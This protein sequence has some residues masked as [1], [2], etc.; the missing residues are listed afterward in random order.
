[1]SQRCQNLRFSQVRAPHQPDEEYG[2]LEAALGA[3]DHHPSYLREVPIADLRDHLKGVEDVRSET[4]KYALSEIDSSLDGYD[5]SADVVDKVENLVAREIARRE[6]QGDLS[7]SR[8]RPRRRR[9][10]LPSASP[11]KPA[12]PT[13]RLLIVDTVNGQTTDAAAADVDL[14]A[15]AGDWLR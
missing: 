7:R 9:R 13:G 5:T 1:L 12:E 15:K 3:F 8:A 6:G 10:S 14:G 11:A 2:L 4:G